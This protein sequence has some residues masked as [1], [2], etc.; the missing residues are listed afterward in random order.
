MSFG[1][2]PREQSSVDYL[3]GEGGLG[4]SPPTY[5]ISQVTVLSCTNSVYP[6]SRR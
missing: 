3:M 2:R 1:D 5:I 6:L 4:V